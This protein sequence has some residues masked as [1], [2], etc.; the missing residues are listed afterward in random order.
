MKIENWPLERIKPYPKNAKKHNDAAILASL[1]DFK[2]DQPIVVDGKGVIIKG[3]GRLKAAQS[4]GM[5]EFPVMVRD[6]LTPDQVK[7]ARIADNSCQVADWD[8]ELLKNEIADL[9]DIDF[10]EY[11]LDVADLKPSGTEGKTD[12][13]EVPE[14]PKTPKSETGKIYSCGNHRVMC[15]DSSLAE[16]FTR[17]LQKEAP[18]LIFT[19]PPYGVAIGAKNRM[20]NSF[21]KA[22]RNLTDIESDQIPVEDLKKMLLAVFANVKK[23]MSEDCSVFV[24]SPQGGE[25][26]MM[27]MMMQESGLTVRHVIN[28]VKNSPTFSMGRL[29]YDYQHEPI[30][31]TWGKK[32]KKIMNGGHKTSVWAVDK[33]RA[34]KEHPTMKPVELPENAIM[35]HTDPNDI[36]FDPF[37]GSGT[38]MIAAEKA[39]RI[40]RGMEIS[41]AYIDVIRKRWAEFVHGSGC[42][43]EALTPVCEV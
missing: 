13:D 37:L 32:H 11:G 26:G 8:M 15:G 3:H 19:D 24:C 43:W 41:P 18:V 35:N 25:L 28:W 33:P 30:L 14:T 12:P 10:G 23:C 4:L 40:C 1:R 5:K 2:P 39:G 9:P 21:Q 38:T 29:D 27:M 31:F 20:L 17:V 36:V 42:D 22:G 7:A 34:C 6:D 16:N